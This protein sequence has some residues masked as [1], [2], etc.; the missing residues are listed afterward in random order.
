MKNVK[1]PTS[2]S[3]REYLIESLHEP[4]EAAGFIGAILEEK[5]PEPALLRNA[6]RKVIE[7]R[8]RMNTLSESAKQHHEKL[9]KMLAESAGSEIY[10]LVELLEALGFKLEITVAD[11]ELSPDSESTDLGESELSPEPVV[12]N[13]S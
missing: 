13:P 6:I 8:I 4:E 10:S 7:A 12:I 5:D 2:D 9:D 3:H 1:A 11:T